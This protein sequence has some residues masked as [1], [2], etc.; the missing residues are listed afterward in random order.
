ML[1]LMGKCMYRW[2]TE[3]NNLYS[4][5][6]LIMHTQGN[7]VIKSVVVTALFTYIRATEAH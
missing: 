7:V 5:R 3:Q 2:V 6:C 1:A 4:E